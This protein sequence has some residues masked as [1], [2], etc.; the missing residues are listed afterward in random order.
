MIDRIDVAA[1]GWGRQTS[2]GVTSMSRRHLGG[3]SCIDRWAACA[4]M[5]VEDGEL[6]AT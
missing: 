6:S 4:V 3:G 1:A 2:A 5:A